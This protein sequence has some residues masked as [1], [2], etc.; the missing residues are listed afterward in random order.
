MLS[1]L[2]CREKKPIKIAMIGL[3]GSGKTSLTYLMK[4]ETPSF[5]LPTYG[6]TSHIIPIQFKNYQICLFDLG[7]SATIRGYWDNYY[8]E[9]HCV[10][11][12][13]DASDP[14]RF[15]EVTMQY[16]SLINQPNL[17]NKPILIICN[18]SDSPNV[19][20]STI[21]STKLNI[22]AQPSNNPFKMIETSTMLNT[23]SIINEGL[24]FLLENVHRKYDSI[25]IK[26]ELNHKEALK[27][28]DSR[29]LLQKQRVQAH[30]ERASS[31]SPSI[32]IIS[33]GKIIQYK[34]ESDNDLDDQIK[35][36][37]MTK[38]MILRRNDIDRPSSAPLGY[39]RK[40]AEDTYDLSF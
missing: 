34:K 5:I 9:V 33:P 36:D 30:K 29:I 31:S 24:M 3:D 4:N 12:V 8:S 37:K 16:E 23:K 2:C 14:D 32:E 35:N 1:W 28:E 38:M 10:I 15:D 39:I 19:V 6:F 22:E 20:S 27:K 17:R 13:I 40:Y 26:I 7:G 25:N 11:F 21:V 18:K